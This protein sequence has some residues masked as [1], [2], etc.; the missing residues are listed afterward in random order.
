MDGNLYGPLVEVDQQALLSNLEIIKSRSSPSKIM[1]VVKANG[2]GH[3][4][5][6][7]TSLLLDHV[8]YFCV[9]RLS[10]ALELRKFN[11]SSRILILEGVYSS[12]DVD[13]CL[14]LD[15]DIV[16]H[17]FEQLSLVEQVADNCKLNIW[18]K[19]DT[20]LNRLGFKSDQWSIVKK[21]ITSRRLS[22]ENTHFISHLAAADDFELDSFTNT[23]FNSFFDFISIN[24]GSNSVLNSAGLLRFNALKFDFVRTGIAL[25]GIIPNAAIL[26]DFN[27]QPVMS[28]Y[29]HLVAIKKI[30]E[31]EVVGYGCTWRA[32]KVCYLGIVG[33]GYGDGYPRMMSNK[34][35]VFINGKKVPVVGN[36]SMD[37]LTVDLGGDVESFCIGDK[38]ELWGKNISINEIAAIS[39]TI[40]YEIL[41]GVSERVSRILV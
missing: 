23:Q 21:W 40:P 16:V 31:G 35:S 5:N 19:I 7:I 20:G 2:Y 33:V 13:L 26:N 25:Y 12:I 14:N 8:D 10:E 29:G 30:L 11:R 38:V 4:L 22:L 24:S 3:G 37:R 28:F 1:A 41:C 6:I 27:L 15:I 9:A 18:F 32:N 17:S 34:A 36:V 39:S